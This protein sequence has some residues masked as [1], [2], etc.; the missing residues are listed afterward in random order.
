MK[1][2]APL[3]NR[4]D[5]KRFSAA[6]ADELYFGFYDE[7]WTEKFGEYMDINRMSGFNK[8][9]NRYDFSEIINI[10]QE[11]RLENM[12]AFITMNANVY[13]TEALAWIKEEYFS[14]LIQAGVSGVI[15]S[16]EDIAIAALNVGL[17]V[18][19][20]TLLGLYNSDIIQYYYSMGIR[21]IIVPR[22]LS[23]YEIA[24]IKDSF[25]DIELEVFFMRRG[26]VFSDAYCLGAHRKECE[27]ICGTLKKINRQIITTPSITYNQQSIELND[28][29]YHEHFH[30]DT[31]GMCSLYR[32]KKMGVTSLKIVGR[33]DVPE[34]VAE[35]IITTKKNMVI[36]QDC[37]NEEDYLSKM[38]MPKNCDKQCQTGLSCY[39]PEVRF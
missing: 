6:G 15:V 33:A 37:I 38:I 18:V 26:C 1:I 12:D 17:Q 21:R 7:S 35:D 14:R 4:E 24:M 8:N 28:T 25:P 39:Y 29:L 27:S 5:I 16:T 10:I 11:I 30:V 34:S 19:A 13:S 20:S 22:D 2:L 32:M 9:A 36:L 23:L 3:N 31:C